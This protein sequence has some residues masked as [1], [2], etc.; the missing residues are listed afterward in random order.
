[1]VLGFFIENDAR[2]K[3]MNV[4]DSSSISAGNV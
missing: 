4:F 1:M 3:D 2:N